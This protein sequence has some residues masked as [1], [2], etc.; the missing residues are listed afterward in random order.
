MKLFP[1]LRLYSYPSCSS[2][3]KAISWLDERN[4]SFDLVNIADNPPSL[5]ELQTVIEKLENRK[6]VFNTRGISY[7]KLGASYINSLNDEKAIELLHEDGKLIK[8][9]LLISNKKDFLIGF[10]PDNWH[11][12]FL[13]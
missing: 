12:F 2:C 11:D 9:P 10:K 8:R 4:I 7:R 5:E 13:D 6:L 3:R 1:G